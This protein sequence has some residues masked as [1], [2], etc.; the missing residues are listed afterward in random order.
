[1][2]NND[3]SQIAQTIGKSRKYKAIYQKTLTRVVMK[4][5]TIRKGKQ[6]EKYARN[7][8]HQIWG[9]YFPL[10]PSFEKMQEN[11]LDNIRKGTSQEEI[12]R[13]IL[14]LHTS[15]K[16][17]LVIAR[18]FY[19]RIFSLI[20]IPA[21]IID[22]GCGLNPLMIPW[23]NLPITTIY[24]AY[25]IDTK[26]VAF[27]RKV[28]AHMPLSPIPNIMSGDV[29]EDTFPYADVVLHL[30]T[31]PSLQ[32]QRKDALQFLLSATRCRYLVISFPVK[33]LGGKQKGMER[34]YESTFLRHADVTK[35]KIKKLLFK[36]ELVFV[37]KNLL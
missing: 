29:L 25:D 26:E 13:R 14:S 8:L 10:R 35:W 1:M 30:K 37:L 4:S 28:S 33:S 31:L 16:E 12:L 22:H 32:L 7:L 34:F 19:E 27:L 5:L 23:M 24:T 11:V 2:T 17:R 3:V 9:A 20:G 6:A 21:S 36:T 15:T 18:E